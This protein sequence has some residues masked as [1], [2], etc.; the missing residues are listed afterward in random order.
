MKSKIYKIFAVLTCIGLL[1]CEKDFLDI[2]DDPNNPLDVSLELLL[3]STQLDM[4]GA[5]GTAGG[6][7]SR[8]TSIYMHHWVERRNTLADYAL[9]GRD[10]G[11]TAPWLVLYTRAL[12]DTEII[13]ENQACRRAVADQGG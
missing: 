12:A 4:A 11:V 10:F 3:P 6:G 1:S 8:V 7:L 9:T 5:L 13:I 2:N